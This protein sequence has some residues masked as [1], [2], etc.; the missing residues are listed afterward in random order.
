MVEY[1]IEVTD[2]L[3]KATCISPYS[4][5]LDKI[6]LFFNV[7]NNSK[8]QQKLIPTNSFT[9]S[10]KLQKIC[11]SKVFDVTG[12]ISFPRVACINFDIVELLSICIDD[13]KN[14]FTVNF[15]EISVLPSTC[16]SLMNL[17][18]CENAILKI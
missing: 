11:N 12:A 3:I 4:N 13:G 7:Y 16:V 8:L 17:D 9:E 14:F 1:I 10:L 2:D 5:I 6:R 18:V 15:D